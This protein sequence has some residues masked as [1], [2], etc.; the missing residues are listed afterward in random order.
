MGYLWT[1]IYLNLGL[2]GRD[3]CPYQGLPR[4]WQP[5]GGEIP[6]SSSWN[7]SSVNC[8]PR[9]LLLQSPF[10][11]SR[12]GY[13]RI[14]SHIEEPSD[15]PQDVPFTPSP[16][17][18]T[19]HRPAARRPR[20]FLDESRLLG[21]LLDE[22][23][24]QGHFLDPWTPLRFTE[25]HWVN[26]GCTIW[27]FHIAMEHPNHKWRFLAGNNHLVNIHKTMENHHAING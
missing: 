4:H 3:P 10:F 18:S 17:P 24:V 25:I 20:R 5:V 15:Y 2:F 6:N 21:L 1:F 22:A 14:I 9:K 26:L 23:R 13:D 27:L 7:L 8:L 16:S 12:I 19:L 11:L